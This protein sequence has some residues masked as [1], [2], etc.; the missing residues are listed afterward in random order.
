MTERN[1]LDCILKQVPA[2]HSRKTLLPLINA[3][4]N[5]GSVFCSDGWKAYYKLAEH[6]DL[7]DV[8]HFPVN[9]SKNYVEP[10]TGAHT[11]TIEGLWGHMKDFLPTRGMRPQDLESF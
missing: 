2:C 8:V 9:H 11:Q 10:D 5:D 6:L 4:C 7:E 1:S 3:H